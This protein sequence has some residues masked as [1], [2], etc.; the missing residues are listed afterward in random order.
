MRG[1]LI[2][3]SLLVGTVLPAGALAAAAQQPKAGPGGIEIRLV[4]LSA[5]SSHD[6]LGRSYIVDR[7]APGTT[8]RRRVQITNATGSAADVGVYAAAATL[9]RGRFGFAGGHSRNELAS[10][11][12][13][14]QGVLRMPAGARRLETVTIDVPNDASSGERYAVVWAE[15]SAPAPVG[16]GVTLVTRVGVRVYLS[17]GPGGALPANFAIGALTATRSG[18]GEPQVVASVHNSGQRSLAIGGE[19]TL[20]KGPGGL[21]AGPF[22]VKLG[23]ALAPDN[24]QVVTVRL[25]KRLPRGPWHAQIRLRSGFLQRGAS[26]TLTFP[27]QS[28]IVQVIPGKSRHLMLF[29]ILL[30]L[31]VAAAIA[32][33]LLRRPRRLNPVPAA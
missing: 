20:S 17:V 6:P 11:M 19:L 27:R 18:A 13:V 9:H 4:D 25:D 10:W 24:S 8:I 1:R 22:S 31:I 2:A 12:S 30:G 21:R 32:L 14:D 5:D 23:A 16:G 15:V 7:L 3:V 26:A 28:G 33:L 29:A